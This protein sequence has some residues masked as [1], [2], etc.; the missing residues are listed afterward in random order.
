MTALPFLC[1]QICCGLVNARFSVFVH[2]W[3]NCPQSVII[4]AIESISVQASLTM[5]VEMSQPSRRQRNTT[6][7]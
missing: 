2:F 6:N 4:V 5:C 1:H 3:L 7:Q